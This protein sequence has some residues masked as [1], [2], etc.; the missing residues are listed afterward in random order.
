MAKY[1]ANRI[2]E[3]IK[4]SVSNF[5]INGAKD[6]RLTTR[7][8]SISSVD[9]SS[10][11]S[12]ATCYISPLCLAD[13]DKDSVYEDVLMGFNKAKHAIR[14][15]LSKDVK[16]RYTPELIFKIDTSLD[17]GMHIDSILEGLK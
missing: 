10:D 8:I 3:E 17:Y 14:G 13:E 5:L 7:I 12:Y 4:K 16:L 2:G 15:Q 11:G 6:P 1:R 9:V